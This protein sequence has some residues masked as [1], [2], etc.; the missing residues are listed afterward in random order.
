ARFRG[1]RRPAELWH[2]PGRRLSPGRHLCRPRAQG[3]EARRPAGGA[4]H[5]VRAGDQPQDCEGARPRGVTDLARDRRRGDRVNRRQL[6][7]V[8]GG[9]AIWPIAAHA[10]PATKLPRIGILSP[11]G[12]AASDSTAA[13]VNAFVQGLHEL[14]YLDGQ[15]VV[16]E[17]TYG[18]WKLER[19]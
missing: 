19:L 6:I 11:G 13:M 1:G 14:G 18:E 4:A 12:S 5:Q 16:I 7:A 3:R 9:I 2:Q 10:Q 17:R 8:L 15:T